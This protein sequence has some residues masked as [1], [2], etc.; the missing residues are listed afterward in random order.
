MFKLLKD[1]FIEHNLHLSLIGS[2]CTDGAPAMLDNCSGF[3][4]LLKK[5]VPTLKVTHCKIHRQTIA[6]KS[7]QKSLKDVFDTCVRIVNYIRKN[8]TSHRIFQS[9][10]AAVGNEHDILLY[11]TDVGGFPEVG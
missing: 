3:A 8:D 10:C 1:F 11:H 5:E 6:P 4:A 9:F 7:M 2:I